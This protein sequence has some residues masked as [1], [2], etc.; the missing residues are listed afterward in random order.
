MITPSRLVVEAVE[1]DNYSKK[2]TQEFVDGDS[3]RYILGCNAWAKSVAEAIEVNGFVDDYAKEDTFCNK[4][5]VDPM[6]LPPNSLI[7]SCVIGVKPLTSLERIKELGCQGLDYYSFRKQS[8][9][10]LKELPFIDGFSSEFT[11]NRDKYEALY[12]SLADDKSKEVLSKLINFRV[13]QN[14]RH[15]DGFTDIQ[16]R[17]YFEPF[18]NLRPQEE[19]FLD[20]GCFDG[21][22]TEEFIKRCPHY[23]GVHIFEP[24]PG[25][26]NRIHQRLSKYQ[27]IH[28]HPFGASDRR[29][30]LRFSVNGSSSAVTKEGELE[31]SVRRIDDVID[32]PFTFLKMD[33]EG[34]EY[35]ALEGA[36]VSIQKFAPRLA[37]AVYHR[38]NDLWKI[39]ELV[40]SF[41]DD[42][43][44]YLRHYTEGIT[45]TIMFFM[46]KNMK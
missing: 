32:E 22:T 30:R 8:N 43:N 2:F 28:Y 9:L 7:L 10:S 15:L 39:P 17:Q 5:I 29:G 19:V 13:S 23:S 14:I 4:P 3:P 21:F 24:E 20:V 6:T 35:F 11:D 42:Y 25:N 38:V 44:V 36:K 27:H 26:M 1:D 12:A 34:G 33:I 18:L 16:Y 46:P 45:E 40:L 41:R 37:V 31:I